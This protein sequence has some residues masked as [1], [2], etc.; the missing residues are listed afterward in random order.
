MNNKKILH[1]II[2]DLWDLIKTANKYECEKLTDSEWEEFICKAN[3]YTTKYRQTGKELE[4][5]LT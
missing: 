5:C 1:G 4:I 2:L 3:Q